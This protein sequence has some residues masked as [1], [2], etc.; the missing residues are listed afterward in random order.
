MN[1]SHS[2]E[3][4]K[5]CSLLGELRL[6]AMQ[7][8]ACV[9]GL[10]TVFLGLAHM[11]HAQWQTQSIT[12]KPGW[13]AVYLHVDASHYG[14]ADVTPEPIDEIWLWNRVSSGDR[15]M[16]NPATPTPSQDWVS[17]NRI[18]LASDTLGKM[19]GNA[20][21]LVRNSSDSDYEW[22]IRGKP[23]PP[24]VASYGWTSRGVNLIG[25]SVPETG[26][27]TFTKFL[28]PVQRLATRGEFY[29]YDDGHQDLTPSRFDA[30]FNSVQVHRGQAY[31]IR[32]AGEF[33]RYFGPFE[34]VLGDLSGIHFGDST[35]RSSLRVRN[36]TTSELKVNLSLL[37]SENAPTGQKSIT[38]K[39][40]LL[41]RGAMDI[42][43]LTFAAETFADPRQIILAPKGQSGSEVELILGVDRSQ[44]GSDTD[45][46]YAGIL[47]LS[48][49]LG[50]AQVDMAVSAQPASDE[51]L[52]VGTA[53]VNQVGH[54]L[55]TY[56][57]DAK[58]RILNADGS[59]KVKGTNTDLGTVSQPAQLRLILHRGTYG[60][61]VSGTRLMQRV[62][63]GV[64][65]NDEEILTTT[66]AALA[67]DQLASAR[68]ISA[69]H[70]PFTKENTLWNF[71]G[72]FAQGKSMTAIVNLSYTD[73]QSNPF[74]HTYHPDHDN[75][76]PLYEKQ[77]GRGL[78]SYGLQ[79][80]IKLTF[81]QAGTDFGS[82]V[83]GKQQ[84]GGIY[85]ETITLKG[86]GTGDSAETFELKTSGGFSINRISSIEA[87]TAAP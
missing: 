4:F 1:P 57:K 80:S 83:T 13:N 45:T 27:P 19:I 37:A 49:T 38:G 69:V 44:M 59:Y 84:R 52:W 60:N 29:R 18:P 47:R 2:K 16:S 31:W 87:L 63:H 30:F 85:T 64:N 86:S 62:F 6:M 39:I 25:F 26:A 66:Q 24:T 22:K 81:S 56:E 3:S 74:L 15:F 9:S 34:V 14:V 51:G 55:K 8:L 61:T 65:T 43:N 48:D 28:G 78:E 76:D 12:L 42:N 68:R 17:W 46:L 40:P 72:D 41:L 79:R 77:Q 21:Y 11:A 10:F 33:N 75:L 32:H 82:L 20:A 35:S 70:L 7:R 67:P 53:V 71:T 54:Y 5:P 50:H 36:H 23:L 58:G 73:H